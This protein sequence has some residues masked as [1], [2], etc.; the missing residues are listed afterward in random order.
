[1]ISKLGL[2]DDS[3]GSF[4]VIIIGK[5]NRLLVGGKDMIKGVG[6]DIVE[7]ARFGREVRNN[8]AF[9][10]KVLTTAEYAAYERLSGLPQTRFLA[11]RF[12][13]KESF[14]KAF[15]TGLGAAVSF[16]DIETLN[17][18]VGKPETTCTKYTGNIFTAISHTEQNL[19]SMVILED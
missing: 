2:T 6:N 8:D 1:M 14:A 12:S 9:A 10:K 15:G 16:Q 13:V 18:E 19:I 7:L 5:T 3:V 4:F 11:G 17:N